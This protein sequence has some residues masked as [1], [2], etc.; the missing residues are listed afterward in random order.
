MVMK[1]TTL[2]PTSAAQPVCDVQDPSASPH[3]LPPQNQ[4]ESTSHQ[5]SQGEKY[6]GPQDLDHCSQSPVPAQMPHIAEM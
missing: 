6:L 2:L 1:T 3:A 4:G 5:Q